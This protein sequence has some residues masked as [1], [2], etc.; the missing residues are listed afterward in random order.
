MKKKLIFTLWIIS[1]LT[2]HAQ[3]SRSVDVTTP[4]TL[5]GFISKFEQTNLITLSVS[6]NIDARDFAF[7][8]DKIKKL[9]TLNLIDA[10]IKTYS[11]TDGTNPGVET[12]YPANEIPAYAFYNPVLL[13]YKPTLTEVNLPGNTESIGYLA[14][15]YCWNLTSI[16]IPASVKSIA[17]YAFYGCYALDSFSVNNSNTKFSSTS[18]VLFNKTQD[19]LLVCPNAK[20]GS[21]T[22]PSTVKHIANSAFENC[23]SLTAVTIPASLNSTG[24]YAFAYCSGI[25]GNLT[26]P[27]NV[28]TLGDGAFYGCY[29]LTGTINIPATLTD[30]GNFCF[31]ECNN[32][33][34]F[35]VNSAN[36]YYASS[37]DVLYSKNIDTLFICPGAKTGTFIIP[38]TVKLIGSHAF[39]NCSKLSGSLTIPQL[40]D[41]IGYY[42]FYGCS[43]ISDFAV[44]LLNQYFFAENGILYSKSKERLLICPTGKSGNIS[45]AASIQSIDPGA[46][47][48]CKN[49]IG[50]I[51]L[52]ASLIY[53]GEYAFYNCSG[54]SS[55]TVDAANEFFCAADGVLFSKNQDLLYLCPLSKSGTYSIPTSV[56][57]IGYAA[58]DG[59]LNL[60]GINIGE[61]VQE[62][63]AYAFEYCTGIN[64]LSIPQ[65][66][67]TIG[68]G[69][70]YACSNLNDLRVAKSV[71]PVIDYY[72][73]EL[74]N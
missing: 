2:L 66:V 42:A 15:Y 65:N 21:Y 8:R 46:F 63:G 74:I 3:I 34:S 36:P 47:N 39:Y 28:K 60:T 10:N 30:L 22:I 67:N 23:Y 56:Q 13:S 43:Q 73:L 57:Y 51:H 50:N 1:A 70:F 20:T 45:L 37:N 40:T 72:A 27:N 7:I 32:L 14:F 35:S 4:G 64:R 38:N 11:G 41:Y 33:K 17:E 68:T 55:F 54:I 12:S 62:I 52:P 59:C 49:I 29:N 9:S 24:T 44:N 16:I 25:S 31:L 58:F 48:N 53:L 69:A 71:P 19:T 6:G 18:G 26:I 5:S 61:S